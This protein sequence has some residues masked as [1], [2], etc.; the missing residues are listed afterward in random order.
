MM[1]IT[2]TPKTIRPHVVMAEMEHEDGYRL[3]SKPMSRLELT[4]WIFEHR[5][6]GYEVSDYD[7]ASTCWCV[8]DYLK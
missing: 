6:V 8:P 3:W 2:S 5:K 4:G 1:T 7:C